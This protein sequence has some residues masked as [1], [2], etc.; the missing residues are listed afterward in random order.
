MSMMDETFSREDLMV[1]CSMHVRSAANVG[2]PP[3]LCN[4][5]ER[6]RKVVYIQPYRYGERNLINHNTP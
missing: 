4:V 1:D 6:T 2:D 3:Y 5:K